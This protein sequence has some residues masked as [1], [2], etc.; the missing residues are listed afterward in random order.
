MTGIF[1]DATRGAGGLITV[2][3]TLLTVLGT[4]L[5]VTIT[6]ASVKSALFST[7]P[8]TATARATRVA[9]VFVALAGAATVGISTLVGRNAKKAEAAKAQESQQAADA[10]GYIRTNNLS[11]IE[12]AEEAIAKAKEFE[13]L[14]I[15]PTDSDAAKEAYKEIQLS[16]MAISDYVGDI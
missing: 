11:K 10:V 5:A 3:G 14:S 15:M 9:A 4:I 13:E 12:R 6:I 2:L 7:D 8:I 16:T 1:S